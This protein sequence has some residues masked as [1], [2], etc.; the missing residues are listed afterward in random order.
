MASC[1]LMMIGLIGDLHIG[2][3]LEAK[4]RLS[5]AYLY[6]IPLSNANNSLEATPSFVG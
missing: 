3:V 1:A 2:K 5:F 4:P 6:I